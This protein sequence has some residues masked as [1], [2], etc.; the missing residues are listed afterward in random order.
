MSW[1]RKTHIAAVVVT[2]LLLALILWQVNLP[3]LLHS[4]KGIVWEW[5]I[6]V[7]L[8]NVANTWLEAFR[9]RLILSSVKKETHTLNTFAAMLVG[10]VG[11]TV[12]PLRLGDGARAFYLARRERIAVASSLGTVM[13]DRILDVTFF[14]IMGVLT[15]LFY[16]FPRLVERAG[17]VAGIAVAV[18]LIVCIALVIFRLHL[19]F[20][21]KGRLGSKLAGQIRRFTVGLSSLRKAGV[22]LPA[23]VLSALSWGLRAAMIACMFKAFSFEL[24]HVA[25]FVVLIFT[26]LGIAAVSTPANLGGFELSTLA[27]FKLF[28]ADTERALSCAI[29]FHAVEV[30]P[31]VLLGLLAL[32]MSGLSSR[33]ILEQKELS[34]AQFP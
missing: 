16:H 32:S 12:L 25:A 5:V 17:F 29:V 21:L 14:L 6:G 30:V 15:G 28:G 11:N 10:V 13:L 26:N 3:K 9:W 24:P 31:M 7:L 27:A 19:K 8:L 2:L 1:Q 23:G 20:N 4:F 34:T 18:A 22:L 33:E